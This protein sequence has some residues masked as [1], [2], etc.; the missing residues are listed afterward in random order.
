MADILAYWHAVELFDPHDIPRPRRRENLTRRPGTRCVQT[1]SLVAGEPLPPLPWQPGHARYGEPLENSWYG[2]AWR[3]MVY[4]GVF[5]FR[6]VRAALAKV[7]GYTEDEDY[8]G[9]QDGD[10]ALFAFTVDADGVLIDDTAVFSSCAW[11]TGR[12][13]RP[14]PG[15]TGWLDGFDKVAGECEQALYRL[16][17]RPV[18]YLPSQPDGASGESRD[19]QVIVTDILGAAAAGAVAALIGVVAPVVGGVISAGALAGAAGS[20]INRV[21]QRAEKSEQ[22]NRPGTNAPRPATPDPVPPPEPTAR[23]HGRPVQLP[24]LVA[25]AAHVADILALPSGV[26]NAMELR[27][28]STPARRKKDGTLPDPEAVFLSSPVVPDLEQIKKAARLGPARPWRITSALLA[29]ANA[30]SISGT[31]VRQS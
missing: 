1:I 4:G 6:E 5:S 31:I 19:W 28:V 26:A 20:I 7:L 2:S 27:V 23:G 17:A 13:Y 15:A 18:S 25:F 8:A 12:L 29:Q 3:H 16:L 21:T 14:G 24:D 22:P 11:A 10:G 30:A 9:T